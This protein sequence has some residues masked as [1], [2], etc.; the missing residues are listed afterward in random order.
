MMD[1]F[2]WQVQDVKGWIG[3]RLQ[4]DSSEFDWEAAWTEVF[5]HSNKLREPTKFLWVEKVDEIRRGGEK[6]REVQTSILH[7]ETKCGYLY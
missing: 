5:P 3:V 1:V 4:T 7:S 6:Q 2:T